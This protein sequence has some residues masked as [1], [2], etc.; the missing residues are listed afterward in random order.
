MPP[1]FG[2]PAIN[3]LLTDPTPR[4]TSAVAESALC[5]REIA[6]IGSSENLLFSFVRLQLTES[7][8]R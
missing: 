3:C 5:S 8:F 2:F 4:Q 6:I 1:Y 7:H